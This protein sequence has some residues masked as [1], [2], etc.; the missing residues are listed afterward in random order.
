MGGNEKRSASTR[1]REETR[2]KGRGV[3]KRIKRAIAG[4]LVG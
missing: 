4:S 1:K 3:V 2:G